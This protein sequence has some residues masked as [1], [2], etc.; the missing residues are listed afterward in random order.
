MPKLTYA[1]NNLYLILVFIVPGFIALSVRS[2]FI[3][4]KNLNGRSRSKASLLSYLNRSQSS[5]ER[6]WFS[7]SV[8]PCVA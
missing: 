2:Q 4:W 6:D 1:L 7:L 5:N 8:D 3:T